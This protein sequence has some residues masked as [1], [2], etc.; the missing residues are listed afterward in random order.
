MKIPHYHNHY[1]TEIPQL[2]PPSPHH[3]QC[4]VLII[5]ITTISITITNTTNYRLTIN[6]IL[7]YGI[8]RALSSQHVVWGVLVNHR[9]CLRNSSILPITSFGGSRL[10]W[11]IGL[12]WRNQFTCWWS[13]RGWRWWWLHG[14]RQGCIEWHEL[15][16]WFDNWF[17]PRRKLP[18]GFNCH[19]QNSFLHLSLGL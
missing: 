7:L 19:L 8:I 12:W 15:R 6:A 3:Q 2:P 16:F 14:G 4:T 9:L 18:D 1:H 10:N 13:N 11:H 17:G 5:N